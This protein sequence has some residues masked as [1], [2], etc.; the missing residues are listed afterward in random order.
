M[1]YACGRLEI[2]MPLKSCGAQALF[3]A[4]RSVFDAPCPL[5]PLFISYVE[6]SALLYN[7]SSPF[8][9]AQASWANATDVYRAHRSGKLVVYLG[10]RAR[11]SPCPHLHIHHVDR[12]CLPPRSL[13]HPPLF[14]SLPFLRPYPPRLHP[15]PAVLFLSAADL[16][17]NSPSVN[18]W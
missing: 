2:E 8:T 11:I 5:R 3:S 13:P 15:A 9:S 1:P 6:R 14:T 16:A 7:F 10:L 4:Q 18:N 12:L 17:A